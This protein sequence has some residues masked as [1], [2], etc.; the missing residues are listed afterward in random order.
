MHGKGI[1]AADESSGTIAKRFADV[2]QDPT[3]ENVADYRGML[4]TTEEIENYISGVILYDATVRTPAEQSYCFGKTVVDHLLSKNIIPGIKVDKGTIKHPNNANYKITIGLDDLEQRLIEYGNMG[5][6]FAKWRA[7]IG[8][9]TNLHYPSN[10]YIKTLAVHL[11]QYAKVCQDNNVLPIVEPE[12]LVA[13]HDG[14]SLGQI[15]ELTSNVLRIVFNEL[16]DWKVDLSAI[17]LKTNMV[18]TGY[19]MRAYRKWGNTST[20]SD[21]AK[22]TLDALKDS[23]P[24]SVPG[25]MF[26]SGGQ[27]AIQATENLNEINKAKNG[28][29][30]RLSFSYGRALQQEAIELWAKARIEGNNNNSVAQEAFLHRAKQVA[31]ASIGTYDI[32][33]EQTA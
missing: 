30:W 27:S 32:T 15:K 12:V 1:L 11:A 28:C 13:D 9:L 10:S 26:L 6:R 29:P 5:C 18:L 33:V 8:G 2:R 24:V 31:Y 19:D 4:F 21:I 3:P 20:T 25:I 22:R 23:V 14:S 17:L 16:L 7:V